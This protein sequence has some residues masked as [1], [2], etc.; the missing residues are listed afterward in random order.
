MSV[1]DVSRGER[2]ITKGK[3]NSF[4]PLG[5]IGRTDIER[6]IP[7]SNAKLEPALGVDG[8]FVLPHAP[9]VIVSTSSSTTATRSVDSSIDLAQGHF[10]EAHVRGWGRGG[11]R[12]LTFC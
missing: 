2:R 7:C 11:G 3:I 5:K 1:Q 10:K 4:F 12:S 9:R 6:I 8:H